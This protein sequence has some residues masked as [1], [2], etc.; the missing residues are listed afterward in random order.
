[1]GILLEEID[2]LMLTLKELEESHLTQEVRSSSLELDRL[3]ADDFFEFGSSGN[4]YWKSD[5]IGDGGVEV[6]QMSL[7]DFNVHP[8]SP[9]VVLAT[10]RV[11]DTTRQQSTLR[12]SIWKYIDG[13]WQ[14]FFHQGTIKK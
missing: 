8:L 4:V 7:Y 14:M 9:E 10:Y 2:K 1:M 13:R 11:E 3:L 12:S 6:R 5:C